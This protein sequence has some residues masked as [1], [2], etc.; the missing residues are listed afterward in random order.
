MPNKT[1]PRKKQKLYKHCMISNHQHLPSKLNYVLGAPLQFCLTWDL[2]C[3]ILTSGKFLK[4]C[5]WKAGIDL[6][7]HHWHSD[8]PDREQNLIWTGAL[9]LITCSGINSIS[10]NSLSGRRSHLWVV[11]TS[12]KQVVWVRQCFFSESRKT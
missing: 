12:D 7:T 9:L 6:T 5:V 1:S 3:M 11:L 4:E 8:F 2:R 10:V